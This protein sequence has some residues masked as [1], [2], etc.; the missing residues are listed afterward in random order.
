MFTTE[1]KGLQFPAPDRVDDPLIALQEPQCDPADVRQTGVFR[2]NER[3][4]FIERTLDLFVFR[5]APA[6]LADQ[7]TGGNISDALKELRH[8]AADT[9]GGKDNRDPQFPSQRTVIDRYS[10]SLSL[11]DKIDAN[12]RFVCDPENLKDEIKIPLQAR[13]IDDHNRNI[14]PAE[15]DEVPRYLFIRARSHQRIRSRKIHH[16]VLATIRGKR[17][18]CTRNSLAWPIARVL[19]ETCQIVED[20]ALPDIWIPGERYH[21]V[22]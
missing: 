16:L 3:N 4:E 22:S 12:D 7:R 18:L 10:L 1:S 9:G 20:R 14:R 19:P 8:A 6:R 11:V 5:P 2:P 21:V 15:K 17:T 13:C